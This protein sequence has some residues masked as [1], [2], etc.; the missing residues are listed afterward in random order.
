M[1][2]KARSSFPAAFCGKP[3][4]ARQVGDLSGSHGEQKGIF[5]VSQAR[6]V[7]QAAAAAVVA[8]ALFAGGNAQANLIQN[9][10]FSAN[11]SSYTVWPGNSSQASN[12]A[13][14]AAPTDWSVL[15]TSG[16]TTGGQMGINGPDTGFY[17][18]PPSGQTAEPFAPTTPGTSDFAFLQGALGVP[19][20]SQ[21]VATTAG[22]AYSLSYEGA[23]RS[24]ETND[25]L[26]VVLTDMVNNTQ[27]T[28]QVPTIS[29]SVF[30]TFTLNFT[31]PSAST[32]V[33]FANDTI[34]AGGGTVDVANVS[35]NA[36]PEPAALGLA[37]AGILGMLLIRRRPRA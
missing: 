16:P 12:N 8:A 17:S 22:Q 29:N 23:A 11:A 25:V 19:S 31:A 33:T 36:V 1:S 14:P 35:L 18:N 9:G 34:Q 13:N 32:E 2:T 20:I 28:Q 6:F 24:G 27:I 7:V 5:V 30:A 4:P 26:D 37:G 15:Y 10:D 3:Q 21:T